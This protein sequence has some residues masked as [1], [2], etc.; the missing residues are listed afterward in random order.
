MFQ[1]IRQFVSQIWQNNQRSL[2]GKFVLGLG[3][4]LCERAI[5]YFSEILLQEIYF[6]NGMLE[7]REYLNKSLTESITPTLTYYIIRLNRNLLKG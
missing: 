7:V 4:P 2:T 5:R 1:I 3:Y 6:K